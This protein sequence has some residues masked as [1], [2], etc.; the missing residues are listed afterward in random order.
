MP[1]FV[2]TYILWFAVLIPR[3]ICCGSRGSMTCGK[4]TRNAEK[5]NKQ[6]CLPVTDA[7]TVDLAASSH[8]SVMSRRSSKRPPAGIGECRNFSDLLG[9]ST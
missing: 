4:R 6:V 2:F 3:E 1:G 7:G 5:N 9:Y 8:F